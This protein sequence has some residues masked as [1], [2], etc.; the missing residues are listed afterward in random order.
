[1]RFVKIDSPKSFFDKEKNILEQTVAVVRDAF[2]SPMEFED[3]YAH[4][5]SPEKVYLVF[6]GKDVIGMGSYGERIFS[7][8]PTLIVDG[9]AIR[10]SFQGKGIFGGL[11]DLV[12][13]GEKL[14]CLRTQSPQMYRALEKKCRFVYPGKDVRI[15]EAI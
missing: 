6:E 3:V 12:L 11:T 2:A 15:P 7:G 9:I 5:T 14:I 13:N 4:L 1:M 8:I 10:E